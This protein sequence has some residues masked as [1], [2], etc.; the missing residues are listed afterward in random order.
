MLSSYYKKE[1]VNEN[2]TC[3][4]AGQG[5]SR[6]IKMFLQLIFI[7]SY[8]RKQ[9]QWMSSCIS[10]LRQIFS[11]ITILKNSL[12]MQDSASANCKQEIV[13][14]QCCIPVRAWWSWLFRL[15]GVCKHQLLFHQMQLVWDMQ[16]ASCCSDLREVAP[17]STV[18]LALRVSHRTENPSKGK[19]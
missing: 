7:C 4:L 18:R 9:R 19:F 1:Q 12:H 5:H 6:V 8:I 2:Q 13:Y 17:L 16:T 15:V 3:G 11:R 10:I 14:T